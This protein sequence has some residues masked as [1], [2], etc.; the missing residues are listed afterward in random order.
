MI[1]PLW[2]LPDLQARVSRFERGIFSRPS[3]KDQVCPA[4]SL[5]RRQSCRGGNL[6]L[7]CVAFLTALFLFALPG[8]SAQQSRIGVPSES[9]V[10]VRPTESIA[11]PETRTPAPRKPV[12]QEITFMGLIPGG[13]Y[14]FIST[15][16]RCTAWTVGVEYD[17]NSWGHLLKSRVDY[18]L[19]VMPFVL[20]S[21]PAKADFWGN[22]KSPYQQHLY[23]VSVS[24]F[25]F[26]FLWRENAR[27]KPYL[28]TKLGAIAFNKKAM[29]EAASYANFNIQAAFGMQF[30]LSDRIDL[31]VEPFEFFHVSNGYLA[32]S[33]PGM[34]ELGTRYG[35]S[36]HLRRRG[37]I[38]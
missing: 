20:L 25:G 35:I 18:L 4:V 38:R 27:W 19:E 2:A 33:N 34:D 5:L 16:T 9:A 8:A 7:A 30:R 23:G 26:R 36:Y 11:I 1:H 14:Q 28:S 10:S 37:E 13:D 29:S 21:E 31:R 12:A 15:T 17:R 24:P 6:R 3:S 32:A 22:A